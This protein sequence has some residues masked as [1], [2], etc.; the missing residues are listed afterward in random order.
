MGDKPCKGLLLIVVKVL[1]E[2]VLYTYGMIMDN[3]GKI[4]FLLEMWVYKGVEVKF[5]DVR[6][7]HKFTVDADWQIMVTFTG[8][9]NPVPRKYN[10]WYEDDVEITSITPIPNPPKLLPVGTKVRVFE[11]YKDK[12]WKMEWLY[13]VYEELDSQYALLWL[14]GWQ[15][16]VVPARAVVPVLE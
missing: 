12:Y 3:Y 6:I 9:K 8:E 16:Y 5:A 7:T 4:K 11:E 2:I 10:W 15:S 14:D 13:S 1:G